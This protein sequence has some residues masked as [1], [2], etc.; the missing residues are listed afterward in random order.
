MAIKKDINSHEAIE[1]FIKHS[2]FLKDYESS[3][4]IIL[5][6][7]HDYNLAKKEIIRKYYN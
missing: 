5:G 6:E 2:L 7:K 3:D 1:L 4:K